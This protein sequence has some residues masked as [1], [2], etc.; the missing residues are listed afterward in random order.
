M[1]FEIRKMPE[2]ERN[3]NVI[4]DEQQR[5]NSRNRKIRDVLISPFVATAIVRVIEIQKVLLAE[6]AEVVA[7][8]DVEGRVEDVE[9][10]SC[11]QNSAV[12]TEVVGG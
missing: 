2:D 12:N 4:D 6:A 7:R 5:N 3:N 11:I 8:L 10:R 9:I 1:A